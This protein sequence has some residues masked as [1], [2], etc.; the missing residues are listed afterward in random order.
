MNDKSWKGAFNMKRYMI[1]SLCVLLAALMILGAPALAEV[2]AG[3]TAALYTVPVRADAAGVVEALY[4][5]VGSVV[6]SSTSP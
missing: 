6:K 3:T 4:A 2:Y 5:P 1:C